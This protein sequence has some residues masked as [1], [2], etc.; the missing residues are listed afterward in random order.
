MKNW[1]RLL[2]PKHYLK[3]VLVLL[4]LVFSGR[5][6]EGAVLRAALGAFAAFCLLSSAVYI[7]ND[8]RDAPADRENPA[9]CMRPIASGAVSVAG[10]AV[11]CV[12][13]LCAVVALGLAFHFPLGGWVTL[14]AYLVVNVGYSL[15]LK[16]IPLLDVA[17]LVSGFLL[18]ML[19]G[20]LVTGIEISGWLYLT[21]I[22]ISFY[23]SLGKRRGELRSR[24]ESSRAVL[25]YY[26][27]A[28]LDKNMHTCLT[29]AI[30]FY[31][32]WSVNSGH[33][34]MVWTVPLVILLCMKYS[35][36]VEGSS[37][38]DPIEVIY[39]DKVLMLLAAVFAGLTLGL[40]Y[41]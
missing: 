40:I 30:V 7:L 38:G 14:A 22:A 34:H 2:R 39:Q 32:L 11:L 13:L 9:K 16:N 3:N 36:T 31:S 4:P 8:L 27:E 10:A 6:G 12:L 1:I 15:G 21:V 35:M 37:D 41:L 18:R 28:F 25:K 23:L 20:A 29:L 5:L 19:C 33:A 24:G 17:L 26:N